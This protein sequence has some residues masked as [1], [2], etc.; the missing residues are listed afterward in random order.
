M[1]VRG[2]LWG[3]LA[4]VVALTQMGC[5]QPKPNYE[6]LKQRIQKRKSELARLYADP[7]YD[8][9][10]IIKCAQEFLFETMVAQVFPAWYGT[11]WSFHGTTTEP[12][13]GTIACGYFVTT[14]LRDLG[15]DI[16]RIRWAQ[17]PSESMIKEMTSRDNIKRYS[18]VDIATIESDVKRWGDG[19]YVVG[20]DSH[21]GF[22]VC[23]GGQCMFVHSDYYNPATGVKSEALDS[24]NPLKH[25][26][27]R[28]V[29]KI[30]TDEMV[31][32]WLLSEAIP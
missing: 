14:T 6:E 27:Y 28:V 16:P 7:E 13:K 22:I 30:L 11:P 32:K 25:S 8:K 4:L 3:V 12:Q 23:R 5:A 26:K 15:F 1:I 29:G 19:L 2:S 21:V 18:S 20:M 31:R 17:L 10:S 24:E 9:D